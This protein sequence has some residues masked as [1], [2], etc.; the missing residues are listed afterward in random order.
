M[1]FVDIRQQLVKEWNQ[2][3]K[4]GSNINCPDL[5]D[6]TFKHTYY[7]QKNWQQTTKTN[8]NEYKD[9]HKDFQITVHENILKEIPFVHMLEMK[10][11]LEILNHVENQKINSNINII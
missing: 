8:P 3:L 7:I 9:H 6:K 4:A 2:V 5:L 10:E 1:V 11:P